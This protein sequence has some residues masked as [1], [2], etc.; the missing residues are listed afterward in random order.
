M[1]KSETLAFVLAFLFGPIGMFYSGWKA[2]AVSLV[3]HVA[4][5]IWVPVIGNVTLWF[6][7]LFWAIGDVRAYNKAQAVPK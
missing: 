2:A 3:L 6:A 1:K 4:S 7:G 5:W